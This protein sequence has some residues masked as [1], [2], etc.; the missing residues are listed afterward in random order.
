MLIARTKMP[1]IKNCTC[2]SEADV[3][4]LKVR[5]EQKKDSKQVHVVQCF[6]C[7]LSVEGG[8][9]YEAITFWNDGK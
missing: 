1:K 8:T 2:G 9:K 5:F 4:K 6:S 7:G 3:K